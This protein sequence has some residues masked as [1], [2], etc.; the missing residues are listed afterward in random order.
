MN[1]Q[2]NDNLLFSCCCGQQGHYSYKQVCDCQAG[3]FTANLTCIKHELRREDRY[4]QTALNVYA[5]VTRMYPSSNIWVAGHSLGGSI[6][7]LVGLTF[8]VPAITFEAPPDA[9]SAT[10]LGLPIPP[11]AVSLQGRKYTGTHHFGHTADPVYMGACNGVL[12]SCSLFGFAFESQCF[13]GVRCVY[14][15]VGDKG[16]RLS[17]ANHR[18]NDVISGVLEVYNETA[19]C[20]ADTECADCYEW[21]FEDG[22]PKPTTSTKS[23]TT[24][25]IT[26]KPTTITI[27]AKH[28]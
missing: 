8:G 22:K 23:T 28:G 2:I 21:Y 1:D 4:Y 26:S 27:P 24:T 14:D 10:R 15:T 6:S 3:T 25:S 7:S 11:D 12:S 5:N 9:L 18:I 20:E 17:I 19:T 13:T 16:W